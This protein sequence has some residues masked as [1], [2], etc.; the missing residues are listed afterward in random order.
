LSSLQKIAVATVLLVLVGSTAF[1]NPSGYVLLK[2]DDD[3]GT[4]TSNVSLP[5]H[6]QG[7]AY[8]VKFNPWGTTGLRTG[9]NARWVQIC[10]VMVYLCPPPSFDPYEQTIHILKDDGTG[11][12]DWANPVWVSQP[13]HLFIGSG[14]Y[15]IPVNVSNPE[16][17][18]D[19]LWVNKAD[20]P[21]FWVYSKSGV[22]W[23]NEFQIADGTP[24]AP[25]NT[26]WFNSNQ[27]TAPGD[28]KTRVVVNKHDF[29]AIGIVQPTRDN[30]GYIH[31]TGF[32]L[33]VSGWAEPSVPLRFYIMDATGAVV[34]DETQFWDAVDEQYPV[35]HDFSFNPIAL[36]DGDYQAYFQV[37]YEG[38][39]GG[40]FSIRHDR[41]YS[42][43]LFRG[44][45]TLMEEK[46]LTPNRAP[47]K[48]D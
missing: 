7:D 8:G 45:F 4:F 21:M 16:Y 11:R 38:S 29:A 13:F 37:M 28:I 23:Q 41:N 24:D 43:D 20:V 32:A 17:P 27:I 3:G 22:G 34:Y 19:G 40:N 9:D 36:P 46:K 48:L 18:H 10:T 47:K 35:R 6:A 30:E 14:W 15:T 12:P 31:P 26:Q 1:A 39:A 5:Y 44:F 42:N 33:N 2:Y 25:V